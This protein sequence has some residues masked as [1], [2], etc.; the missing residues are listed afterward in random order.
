MYCTYMICIL[1]KTEKIKNTCTLG[2]YLLRLSITDLR[3][4]VRNAVSELLSV[5]FNFWMTGIKCDCSNRLLLD[6]CVLYKTNQHALQ[7]GYFHSAYLTFDNFCRTMLIFSNTLM[8]TFVASLNKFAQVANHSSVLHSFKNSWSVT[9]W[10]RE[11]NNTNM[12]IHMQPTLHTR[13]HGQKQKDVSGMF[14]QNLV[15][16]LEEAQNGSYT[17]I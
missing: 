4:S 16:R 6:L 5:P 9:E 17:M 12:G 14:T 11:C 8:L 7:A 13:F 3:F 15:S 1:H 10:N 2:S